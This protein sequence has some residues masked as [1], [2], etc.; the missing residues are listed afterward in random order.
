MTGDNYQNLAGRTLIPEPDFVID[1]HTWTLALDV[2]KL[3]IAAAQLC[4]KVKKGIFHQH[5]LTREEVKHALA[6]I[7]DKWEEVSHTLKNEDIRTTVPET[8]QNV[9]HVWTLIGLI[10][11]AGEFSNLCR[12][13]ED[14]RLPADE[15]IKDEGGDQL[16]Y[17]SAHLKQRGISL[18]DAMQYNVLKLQKRYPDGYN[19]DDSINRKE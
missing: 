14:G 8:S 3:G 1:S 11:E 5:G 10:G 4:E 17:L 19:S 9:M 15:A 2:L 7:E 12:P 16:W 13:H 6:E 18:T